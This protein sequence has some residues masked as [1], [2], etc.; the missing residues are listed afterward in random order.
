MIAGGFDGAGPMIEQLASKYGIEIPD[1]LASSI[2]ENSPKV[3]NSIADLFK[4]TRYEVVKEGG[5]T[6]LVVSEQGKPL[7]NYMPK[8]LFLLRIYQ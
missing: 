7:M 3:S 2:T 5:V 1:G 6:N 8:V 4:E